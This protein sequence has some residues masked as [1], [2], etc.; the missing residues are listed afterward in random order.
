M[1]CKLGSIFQPYKNF[2]YPLS[3]SANDYTRAQD[4][5][6]ILARINLPTTVA[7]VYIEKLERDCKHH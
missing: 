4:S 2:T 3:L 5:R 6:R 7:K 1:A